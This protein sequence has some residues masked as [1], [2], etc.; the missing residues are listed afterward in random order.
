MD[1]G[2]S[3]WKTSKDN[4]M[5]TAKANNLPL[6]GS[7]EITR[8]P[9]N[10]FMNDIDGFPSADTMYHHYQKDYKEKQCIQCPNKWWHKKSDPIESDLCWE[11]RKKNVE[12][13]IEQNKDNL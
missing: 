3:I 7:I 4:E 2:S 9:D 11:C 1:N 13:L 5:K 12:K 6:T 8:L 10:E